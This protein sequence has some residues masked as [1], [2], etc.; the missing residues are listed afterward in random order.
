[1]PRRL[2]VFLCLTLVLA[3]CSQYGP[4]ELDRLTKEDPNFKQMIVSRDQI[5]A[6]V[7]AI[8]QDLLAKKKAMDEQVDKLRRD[9]DAYSKAQ[10]QKI[11]K[12]ESVIDANRN[13]LKREVET[14]EADLDAKSAELDRLQKTLADVEKVLRQSHDLT[15]SAP[16]RQKWEERRLMIS[17]KI[18]PL[19]D[20]MQELKAKISLGKRK[21]SFLK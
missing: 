15:L 9:Y 3:G 6:Q 8:K 1:M 5:H 18:K 13:L 14:A 21:V 16:E 20:D 10:N 12:Y 7:H 19:T 17:E 2:F 4:E 11:E